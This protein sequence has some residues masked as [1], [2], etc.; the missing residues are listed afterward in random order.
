MKVSD[1]RLEKLSGWDVIGVQM[2]PDERMWMAQ[3]LELSRKVVEEARRIL[4]NH[5][6][7]GFTGLATLEASLKTLDKMEEE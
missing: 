2:S 6:D 1:K 4:K 3:E 5:R 7:S